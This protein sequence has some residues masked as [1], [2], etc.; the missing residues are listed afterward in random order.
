ML[1]HIL[2]QNFHFVCFEENRYVNEIESSIYKQVRPHEYTR[3][4]KNGRQ[5]VLERVYERI[6]IQKQAKQ[7]HDDIMSEIN[8]HISL[9]KSQQKSDVELDVIEFHKLQSLLRVKRAEKL[10]NKLV[11]AQF[12]REKYKSELKTLKRSDDSGKKEKNEKSASKNMCHTQEHISVGYSK[13]KPFG[14]NLPEINY[15]F[16]CTYLK[17]KKK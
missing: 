13:V 15:L 11:H 10:I 17:W 8:Y 14:L 16:T 5:N 7:K 12:E 6:R 2:F 1:K 9:L 4:P 3:I